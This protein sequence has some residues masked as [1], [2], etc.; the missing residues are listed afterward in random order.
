MQSDKAPGLDGFMTLFFQKCWG[1]LGS[2]V[3]KV[4]EECK[5]RA[6]MLKQ[7]NTT[8]ITLIPKM[9]SPSSFAYFRPISLCNTIYKI[10]TKAISIRIAKIIPI[11]IS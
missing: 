9:A 6:C 7:F 4:V 2:D 1:F 10:V 8:H 5:K 11:I 3:W